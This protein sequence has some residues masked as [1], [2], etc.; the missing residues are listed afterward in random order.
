LLIIGT[1]VLLFRP[2]AHIF[3]REFLLFDVG[4]AFAALG[5]IGMAVVAAIRHT[6]RLYKEERLP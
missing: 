1:V 6:M 4:G 5:M 2:Y 3:G